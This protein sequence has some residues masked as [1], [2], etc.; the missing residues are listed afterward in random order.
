MENGFSR[1]VMKYGVAEKTG[2]V[3]QN[4]A[5]TGYPAFIRAGS[6]SGALLV[7]KDS[8]CLG[9]TPGARAGIFF[10]AVQRACSNSFWSFPEV[11]VR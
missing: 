4:L 11:S 7:P 1:N 10:S 8:L 3:R 6:A 5:K 2:G 9:L